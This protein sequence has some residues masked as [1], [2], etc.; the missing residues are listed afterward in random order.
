MQVAPRLCHKQRVE[1]GGH[2]AQQLS[3]SE[4]Q[5]QNTWHFTDTSTALTV[6]LRVTGVSGGQNVEKE[7]P[8]PASSLWPRAVDAAGSASLLS[9]FGENIMLEC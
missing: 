3:L 1:Q 7:G 5:P 9:W 4:L 8:K 6:I 2:L